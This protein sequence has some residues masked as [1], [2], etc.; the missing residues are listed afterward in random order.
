MVLS[1]RTH[2]ALWLVLCLVLVAA[3]LTLSIWSRKRMGAAHVGAPTGVTLAPVDTVI[4]QPLAAPTTRWV[5]GA[6]LPGSLGRLNATAPFGFLDLDGARLSLRVRPEFMSRAFGA[7]G[8]FVAKAGDGVEVFPARGVFRTPG[9]GL[10]PI[11]RPA[12]YFWTSKQAEVLTA[13]RA[14]GF[15]VAWDERRIRY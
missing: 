10:K 13:L 6:N 3:N 1:V 5:G 14:A 11:G 9:V 7:G 4:R 8:A 15:D 12:L 2:S